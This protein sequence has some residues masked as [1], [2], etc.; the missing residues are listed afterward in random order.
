MHIMVKVF[1]F[2]LLA[3]VLTINFQFNYFNVASLGQF[4]TLK[5][6]SESLVFGKIFAD[7]I[8]KDTQ[9]SNLGFIQ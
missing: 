8:G 9:R 6:G 7:L 3:L 1:S 2:L 4:S 5:D